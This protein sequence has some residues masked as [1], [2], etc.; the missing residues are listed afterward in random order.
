MPSLRS[1]VQHQEAMSVHVKQRRQRVETGIQYIETCLRNP[2]TDG[3]LQ[4]VPRKVR[5]PLGQPLPRASVTTFWCALSQIVECAH[6][7][8]MSVNPPTQDYQLAARLMRCTLG[9]TQH[10]TLKS[11]AHKLSETSM[12]QACLEVCGH[13]LQLAPSNQPRHMPRD[14]SRHGNRAL[15]MLDAVLVCCSL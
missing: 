7:I 11:A 8:G 3:T 2:C 4:I 13:T 9:W 15:P 5:S 12:A 1:V 6:L 14:P 10:L